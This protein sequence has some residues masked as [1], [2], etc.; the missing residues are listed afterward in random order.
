M[1]DPNIL[2][3]VL[4]SVRAKNCS[5]YGHHSETT[6]F[7]SEFASRSTTYTQARAPGTHSISSHASIW[8]G[9][10][11]PEHGLVDQRGE[12]IKP[13]NTVWEWLRE[14]N[15]STGLFTPNVIVG[16]TSNL[17]LGFDYVSGP[18]TAGKLFENAVGPDDLGGASRWQFLRDAIM[19]KQP[20]RGLLNGF[21]YLYNEPD[22]RG[23]VYA[24]EF[25]DWIGGQSGNWG[26]C[27]NL[28]D[29][30]Y[31]YQPTD[32]HDVF[33]GD[34]LKDLYES[35]PAGPQ[36]STYLGDD[37]EPLWKLRSFE[38][39]Y[40][41]AIRQADAAVESIIRGLEKMG[42]L[43]DT[44]VVITS[45]HGEGF[46]EQSKIEKGVPIIDHSWGIAEEQTHVPLVV[47][48]PQQD[49]AKEVD[50]LASIQQF[51]DVVRT[52]VD[53]GSAAEDFRT[54]KTVVYNNRAIL[55]DNTI[56]DSFTH[57]PAC[58][59]PWAA[60]YEDQGDHVK[61]SAT[62]GENAVS[63]RV[64]DAQNVSQV[65]PAD[66]GEISEHIETLDDP[67]IRAGVDESELP[68]ET[69]EKLRQ[70]GYVE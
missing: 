52:A 18:K 34:E 24:D 59:G 33:G 23:R 38:S 48:R 40:D 30:H 58:M 1:S 3:V 14:Q 53:G 20:I 67:Q 2:L 55:D 50:C 65:G 32:E 68:A 12:R 15:Y 29:A 56:P 7:L 9:Y 27:L 4:D 36:P 22:E 47:N 69:Q 11:V 37:S 39:L 31:P 57:K 62:R 43:D 16:E 70:L 66:A 45:D 25:L 5:L 54:K 61:K 46:A 49:Q 41:G 35:V 28:M 10:S 6:P 26:A 13:G 42:I 17:S 64:D 44:L 8:T 63:I 21:W 51:F 19:E 60:I